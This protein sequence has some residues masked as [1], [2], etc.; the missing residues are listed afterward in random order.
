M[1]KQRKQRGTLVMKSSHNSKQQMNYPVATS[2]MASTPQS[3]HNAEWQQKQLS[4]EQYQQRMLQM[5]GQTPSQQYLSQSQQTRTQ[6]GQYMRTNSVPVVVS[7]HVQVH[8]GVGT[9]GRFA[10]VYERE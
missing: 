6:R 7:Q 3:N 10:V 4:M 1:N 9:G 8:G 2:Q 5:Q